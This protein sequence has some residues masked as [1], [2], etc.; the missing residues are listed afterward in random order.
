MLAFE[1]S[2]MGWLLP[3]FPTYDLVVEFLNTVSWADGTQED[4]LR[5]DEEAILWL[6]KRGL[7]GIAVVDRARTRGVAGEARGLRELVRQMVNQRKNGKKVEIDRLN[8][9]MA[10]AR[11]SVELMANEEG[12]LDVVRRYA[13]ATSAQVLSPIAYSAADLLANG[14]F[15][16]IRKCEGEDC[17]M[18]F[19]DRT[20]AHRRRWCNMAI[21][22]NREKVARFRSRMH[23]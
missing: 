18:W 8:R 15:R 7:T 13:C 12:G 19:Y 23:E 20:K 1:E 16:L 21:C 11:Y 2:P 17:V 3:M 9:F 5:T 14:D 4:L 6:E 22:G 10:A